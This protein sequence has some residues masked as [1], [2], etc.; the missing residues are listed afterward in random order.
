MSLRND[1]KKD[2]FTRAFAE[3]RFQELLDKM[4]SIPATVEQCREL[5]ELAERK[6]WEAKKNLDNP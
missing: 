5:R 2:T 6:L 3:Y 1:F 4:Q